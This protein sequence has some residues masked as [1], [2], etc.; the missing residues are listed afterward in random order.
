[1]GAGGG[2]DAGTGA[3]LGA[4]AGALDQISVAVS[5]R[6]AAVGAVLRKPPTSCA[7]SIFSL[8][9][10]YRVTPFRLSG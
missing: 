3:G 8:I 2:G 7:L 6:L 1:M 9:L 10:S 5:S 4:G